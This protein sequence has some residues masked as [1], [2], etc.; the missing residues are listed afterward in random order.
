MYQTI[1]L[2]LPLR[3]GQVN[4]DLK[5]LEDESDLVVDHHIVRIDGSLATED[6]LQHFT[7]G[8]RVKVWAEDVI[9]EAGQ[10]W[11]VAGGSKDGP[12]QLGALSKDKLVDLHSETFINDFS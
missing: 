5:F 9:V 2:Q 11:A 10:A 3:V 7:H 12:E 4:I 1:L 6:Q 8:H